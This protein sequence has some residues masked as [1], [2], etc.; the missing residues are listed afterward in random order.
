MLGMSGVIELRELVF[1]LSRFEPRIY[2]PALHCTVNFEKSSFVAAHALV[3][4]KT[5]TLL[6]E[7]L[8]VVAGAVCH[9]TNRSS[10]SHALAVSGRDTVSAGSS[11]RRRYC[12]AFVSVTRAMRVGFVAYRCSV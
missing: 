2:V 6:N 11:C 10:D 9:A 7:L 3:P 5:R 8:A 1:L 12:G 4:E